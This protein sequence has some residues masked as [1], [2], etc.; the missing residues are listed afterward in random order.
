MKYMALVVY[1]TGLIVSVVSLL[2]L[3][4]NWSGLILLIISS[5]GIVYHRHYDFILLFLPFI[6]F[7]PRDIISNIRTSSF[8]IYTAVVVYEFFLYRILISVGLNFV[9]RTLHPFFWCLFVIY[10]TYESLVHM[11]SSL[12]KPQF[13]VIA[14]K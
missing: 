12:E 11:N 9:A 14:I 2:K 8:V 4:I 6:I 5:L 10:Y 3:G 7:N 13:R 1:L